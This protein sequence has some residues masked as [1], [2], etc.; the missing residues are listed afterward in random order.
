VTRHTTREEEIRARLER[1]CKMAPPTPEGTLVM[2]DGYDNMCGIALVYPERYV[3]V[4]VGLQCTEDI[5]VPNPAMMESL[6]RHGILMPK[7]DPKSLIQ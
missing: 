5:E 1:L 7:V 4:F 2:V 6:V 3:I